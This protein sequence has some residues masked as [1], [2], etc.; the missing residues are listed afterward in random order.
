LR[1]T[2]DPA[3]A[4]EWIDERRVD[5]LIIA[6]CHRRD[7]ALVNAAIDA[8]VPMVAVAP[9]GTLPNVAVLRADNIAAGRA[10]G[11]HLADLGHKRVAFAGGPRVS[12]ESRHRLQGLREELG[13]R[14]VQMQANDICFCA[15]YEA[16]EGAAFADTFLSRTPRATAVVLGNDALALGFM[17][18]AQQRAVRIPDDLSVAGFDGIP[19]GTRSWPSLT[20]M[21]QPMRE[22]GRDACRQL[23]AAIAGAEETTV[24]YSMMLVVRESTAAPRRASGT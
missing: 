23:F 22:M 21:A 12:V 15:S 4:F 16:D 7:K 8:H 18:T 2:Y 9:D 11:A 24:Q 20:T 6:K 3:I 19:E 14:G 13:K 5:G 17:R 1:D 10:L